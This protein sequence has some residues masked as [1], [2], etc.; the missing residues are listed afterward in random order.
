MLKLT[1]AQIKE[2]QESARA[3]VE[4]QQAAM[5]EFVAGHGGTLAAATAGLQEVHGKA[6]FAIAFIYG[7]MRFDPDNI[8]LGFFVEHLWGVGL[9]GGIS[10]VAGAIETPSKNEEWDCQVTNTPGIV[11]GLNINFFKG[12]RPVGAVVGP[13][14]SGGIGLIAGGRGKWT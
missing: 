1:D 11:T 4:A 8:S 10:Y 2:V 13:G 12:G 9:S 7:N 14:L 6:S 5:G 3:Q